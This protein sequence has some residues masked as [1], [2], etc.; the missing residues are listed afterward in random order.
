MSEL[1]PDVWL[2]A[3]RKEQTPFRETLDFVSEHADG[4]LKVSP[5]FYFTEE[6]MKNYLAEHNLPDE[7]DY[8]DPTKVLEK[9]EC[10]LHLADA[11]TA[12]TL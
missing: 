12:I 4:L 2:T 6:D 5:V 7:D 10:G 3:L 11:V 8:F 1:K 9:R